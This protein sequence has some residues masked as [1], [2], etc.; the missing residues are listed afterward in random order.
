LFKN[1]R[2]AL[3][4][5]LPKTPSARNARSASQEGQAIDPLRHSRGVEKPSGLANQGTAVSQGHARQETAQ[6]TST[7]TPADIT[8]SH[9]TIATR[10]SLG[11]AG[12]SRTSSIR[13]KPG[14]TFVCARRKAKRA[15]RQ[16]PGVSLDCQRDLSK[17]LAG[18]SGSE[19]G[20]GISSKGV[21]LQSKACS[22]PARPNSLRV[23]GATR[24]PE[25]ARQA[26]RGGHYEHL[27]TQEPAVVK[28]TRRQARTRNISSQ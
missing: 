3:R 14:E 12:T 15:A 17:N 20:T 6:R 28:S 5:Q 23:D 11:S 1:Q 10:S 4:Q 25:A 21:A 13:V 24:G 7:A 8:G 19:Q 16:L 26:S 2:R 27:M 18:P 22:P 9:V